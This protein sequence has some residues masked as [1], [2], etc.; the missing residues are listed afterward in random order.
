MSHS[1]YSSHKIR[2]NAKPY[3]YIAHPGHELALAIWVRNSQPII[4]ILTDGSGSDN[5]PRLDSS[6]NFIESVNAN[7]GSMFGRFS[8]RK[9]YQR[10]IQKS[11]P[12]FETL[13]K[14]IVCDWR[15]TPPEYIVV[16]ELDGHNPT[17]DLLNLLVSI[18]CEIYSSE[19]G[20]APALYS[21]F[22]NPPL[23]KNHIHK[24]SYL[25]DKSY[26]IKLQDIRE[27]GV[28]PKS[29]DLMTHRLGFDRY[30]SRLND[31]FSDSE[32]ILNLSEDSSL[33]HSMSKPTIEIYESIRQRIQSE[34]LEIELDLTGTSEKTQDDWLRYEFLNLLEYNREPELTQFE[35]T[36]YEL[37]GE[38]KVK[39][40]VYKDM[41]RQQHLVDIWSELTQKLVKHEQ[42][43]NRE[44]ST[45]FGTD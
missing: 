3:L 10:I 18:A 19:S 7:S 14:E 6:K 4:N 21:Y 15:E 27:Y 33:L 37:Y 40:G 29:V 17:H 45:H 12:E 25:D 5:R 43:L 28:K 8:D 16:D 34:N 36:F 9:I 13:I 23:S 31:Y 1:D 38:E 41:L 20:H 24:V 32:S 44:K 42:A 22:L 35:C 39:R 26:Q 2:L 11:I 30:A